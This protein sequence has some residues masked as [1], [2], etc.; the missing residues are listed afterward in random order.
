MRCGSSLHW[1]PLRAARRDTAHRNNPAAPDFVAHRH[2]VQGEE[3]QGEGNRHHQQRPE[4][5]RIDRR[6]AEP[7]DACRLMQRV[8]PFDRKLDD[9]DIDET[10]EDQD[11]R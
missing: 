3:Q 4:E 1:P 6:A 11:G 7:Q 2:H 9:R 10:D 5:L 8:P